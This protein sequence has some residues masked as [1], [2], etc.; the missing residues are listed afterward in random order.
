MKYKAADPPITF[1]EIVMVM[2]NNGNRTEWSQFVNQE[3]DYRQN[4]DNTKSCYLLIKTIIKF[5]KETRHRVYVFIKIST[6][7]SA[8]CETTARAHDAFCPL[9]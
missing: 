5:E 8:K 4:L 1:E 6:F 3:Y 9:T 7:N 2:I